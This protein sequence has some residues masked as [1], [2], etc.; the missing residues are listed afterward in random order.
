MTCPAMKWSRI[1]RSCAVS[2][3]SQMPSWSMFPKL[4]RI[5][6]GSLLP[7]ESFSQTVGPAS[8]NALTTHA[9]VLLSTLGRAPGTNKAT[10]KVSPSKWESSCNATVASSHLLEST[11]AS[12]TCRYCSQLVRTCKPWYLSRRECEGSAQ[13]VGPP[14]SEESETQPS[15]QP[16]SRCRRA[17]V[18]INNFQGTMGRSGLGQHPYPE[19]Q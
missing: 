10:F 18:P 13:R 6:R 16:K 15:C 2:P 8:H 5:W 7:S 19:L 4:S 3:I 14:A 17:T 1:R 9:R 12:N 11:I